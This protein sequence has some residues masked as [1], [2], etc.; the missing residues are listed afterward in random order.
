MEDKLIFEK[1]KAK[2]VHFFKTKSV[3]VFGILLVAIIL[4]IYIRSLP[5]QDHGGAPGLWDIA[6][7]TWTLGPDLDPWL[8]TRYA[9]T[10]IHNGSLPKMDT[11]R[12]VPLGFDTTTELQMV[13]Y[14]I[15]LTHALIGSLGYDSPILAA[16]V[17]PVL[18]FVLIIIS[19]FLFVREIFIT[20]DNPIKASLIALISTF[21]MI[22]VPVFLSRTI[23]GIPEKESVGFFFMFLSF[24]LF[25]KAWKS[26]KMR[27]GIILGILAGISTAL[28]S[29]TWGGVIYAYITIA[30]ATL[31]A[32]ILNKIHKKEFIVYSLWFVSSVA[33][34]LV[35]SNRSSIM[36]IIS[37]L[38]TGSAFL[39]FFVLIVHFTLWKTKLSKLKLLQTKLPKNILSLV[40]AIVLGI[41]IVSILLGPGFIIGKLKDI[42][43]ILFNPITGRWNTTVAE[44][45]QPYF[46]EWG[47][48][49]GP[50][51][52]SVPVL[53]WLFF[54]GSVVLFK[55]MLDTLK[56]GDSW[57]LTLFYILFFIG[58]V[59]SRYAPHPAIFDGEGVIS[60]I[61]Y[62]GGFLLLLGG[63]IYYY[64]KYHK[65]DNKAFEKIKLEYLLLFS[66][67]VL[68]LFTARSAVRLIMVLGP[69]SVIFPAF[70]VVSF[71]DRCLKSKGDKRIY[72]AIV[73]IV[74]VLLVVF[75]FW[76]FY[77][78]TKTQAYKFIPSY[79][80]QQWQKAMGWVRN[81]TS[82]DAVFAHWWDYGYWVQSIG[83][84][85]TVL[86]GGNAMV[87]WNYL[88]GRLV[89]TGDNQ[90]D[91][92]NFLY[93]HNASYLLIDSSDIGKYGAFS[94]IGSDENYD[95]YSWIPVMTSD[96]SQSEETSR[97]ITRV[98]LGGFT[99]DED[100]SYEFNGSVI[101]LFSGRAGLAG[102]LL[103]SLQ[104]NSSMAFKQ[105]IGVFVYN[106]N[107]YRIPLRYLYV[108][109][110]FI[111][112]KE[113]IEATAQVIQSVGS[114]NQGLQVDNLGA[115]IY[116]SPRVM[117]G[118]LAQKYLLN[119]PFNN[120]PNFEITYS[121]PNIIIDSLNRQGANLGEFIYYNGI[122]G[123][124]KI[125]EIKYT[126]DEKAK[127]EY[128]D[129]DASKY[130]SWQL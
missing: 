124:I 88:M 74:L 4:G 10:I 98:Y 93:S 120:F 119:D 92:L 39:V 23:A 90:K 11:L 123:P 104:S 77:K 59:F 96:P 70:M 8:F 32:F 69:I 5:M 115:L 44:N 80:N 42:N 86:D 15:V 84:R 65:E 60:R 101:N 1:R 9:Q 40:I 52:G 128:L 126:G 18:F 27:N 66:L 106:N 31:L 45:R 108:N 50:F 33:L 129:T 113:G 43:Q 116:I 63:L 73:S 85:A 111:D 49:F 105:P 121:E 37:S 7:N 14:M 38:S 56:K 41:L 79:Y 118:Y 107:Q 62:F 55:K 13:S 82:T 17:M 102:I 25:L 30:V 91:A 81:N 22:V 89:L 16:V 99:I 64:S 20:K 95:R 35:F 21:L 68:C 61:V 28:M 48:S 83:D 109:G 97:G 127:Q 103:E 110:Q 78:E 94:A 3:W 54:I 130:L 26:E 51:I 29:L 122:Q 46:T 47:A 2:I 75:I 72:W 67:F 117:R 125:W 6:T 24:Y 100:L 58:L 34:F 19:F 76:N 12:Y 71:C 87:Y 114:S 36:G 53:F 112:F 57:V